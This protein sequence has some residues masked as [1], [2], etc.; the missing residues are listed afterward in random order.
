MWLCVWRVS[1]F[2]L[3]APEEEKGWRQ[4]PAPTLP[5]SLLPLP[6][7]RRRALEQAKRQGQ[8]TSSPWSN[9]LR[10]TQNPKPLRHPSSRQI[11][12]RHKWRTPK[13]SRTIQTFSST[14]CVFL[15]ISA[16]RLEV[17]PS[18]PSPDKTL[19]NMHIRSLASSALDL[20]P[21][22]AAIVASTYTSIHQFLV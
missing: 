4:R 22:R 18:I 6:T 11:R 5:P 21:I 19:T 2:W 8:T 20:T 1:S 14:S 17:H 12:Q 10:T 7:R 13:Q 15:E 16:G 9:P 3:L